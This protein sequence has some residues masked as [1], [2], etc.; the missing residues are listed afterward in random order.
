MGRGKGEDVTFLGPVLSSEYGFGDVCC[1]LGASEAYLRDG[2]PEEKERGWVP[3]KGLQDEVE[4][5]FGERVREDHPCGHLFLRI[6]SVV[7]S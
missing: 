5:Y 7:P 6:I 2:G 1:L 3:S 4:S